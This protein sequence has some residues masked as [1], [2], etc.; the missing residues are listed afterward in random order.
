MSDKEEAGCSANHKRTDLLVTT[1]QGDGTSYD[2]CMRCNWVDIVGVK[3]GCYQVGLKA[4]L[5]NFLSTK[6]PNY[7]L[8]REARELINF[9]LG[10]SEIEEDK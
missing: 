7:R 10:E 1:I 4:S 5:K 3:E 2:Y 6:H 9:L 8:G